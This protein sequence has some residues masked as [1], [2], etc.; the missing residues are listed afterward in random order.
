MDWMPAA[1]REGIITILFISGP[2]VILAA[3]L[4]LAIGIIQAATQIQ[5]QTLGSA[6]KVIGIFIALIVFGFFMFSYLQKYT[7][8]TISR[9]FKL[10]PKLGTYVKPRDNFL[11]KPI[12]EPIEP[13]AQANPEAIPNPDNK[14][15]GLADVTEEPELKQVNQNKTPNTMAAPKSQQREQDPNI[16]KQNLTINNANDVKISP[17]TNPQTKANPTANK[18]TK[19]INQAPK[20]AT[21]TANRKQENPNPTPAPAPSPA[22]ERKSLSDALSR[23]RGSINDFNDTNEGINP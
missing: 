20:P 19:P 8:Q 3:A 15:S 10:V 21:N 6:V 11:E 13:N 22:P 4:G 16:K 5:E 18:A 9:A 7:S 1:I 14:A 23:I 12:E 17:K 2:M